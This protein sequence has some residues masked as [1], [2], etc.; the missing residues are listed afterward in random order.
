MDPISEHGLMLESGSTLQATFKSTQT[1]YEHKVIA[2]INPYEFN[3]SINPSAFG[4]SITG[5]A[6]VKDEMLS[7][8]LS[9]YITTIGLY[10][11]KLQLVAVAK[12]PR[13]IK[14]LA[15]TQQ[16]FVVRFDS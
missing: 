16:S 14:R 6:L 5:S 12:L 1:I 13:P 8:S 7:G 2:T 10:N 3:S 15:K 4:T 9:P 11:D